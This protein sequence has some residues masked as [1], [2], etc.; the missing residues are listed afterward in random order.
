M[1]SLSEGNVCGGLAERSVQDGLQQTMWSN[2]YC[3]GIGWDM[4]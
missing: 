2:L 3:Y 1:T 4:L